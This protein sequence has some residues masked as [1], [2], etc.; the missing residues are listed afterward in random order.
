MSRVKF[1]LDNV[2]KSIDSSLGLY[3][4]VFYPFAFFIFLMCGVTRCGLY[5]MKTITVV[6]TQINLATVLPI[7]LRNY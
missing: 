1:L 5:Y 4:F 6:H 2:N 7:A 3:T